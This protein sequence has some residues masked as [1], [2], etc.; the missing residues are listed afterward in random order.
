VFPVLERAWEILRLC[1]LIYGQVHLDLFAAGKISHPY[2]GLNDFKLRWIAANNW[3]YATNVSGLSRNASS[4][5][6]VFQ[7]LD[8]FTSIDFCGRHI[9]STN[10]QFRQY[11]FDVTQFLGNCTNPTLSINFG[12]AATIAKEIAELPGQESMFNSRPR[13]RIF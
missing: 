11:A 7:G 8:T 6:L 2:Y 12:S 13:W 9:A 1:S 10:N 5:W 3:T 4:T